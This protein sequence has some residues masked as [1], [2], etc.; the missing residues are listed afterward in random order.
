MNPFKNR[1]CLVSFRLTPDELEDL[2][3]ACLLHGARNVSDFARGAVM[4]V[5]GLRPQHDAHLLDRF[6]SVELRLTEMQSSMQ[7]TQE[8]MHGLARA[9]TA[10]EREKEK[11]A[12]HG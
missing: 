5:A 7:H 4:N 1:S 6:S 9:L 11:V 2:R 12:A 8:L 10:R 3:A